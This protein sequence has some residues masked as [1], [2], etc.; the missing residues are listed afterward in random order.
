MSQKRG[1]SKPINKGQNINSSQWNRFRFS[2]FK[3]TMEHKDKIEPSL[4][5]ISS[6]KIDEP[7]EETQFSCLGRNTKVSKD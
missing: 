5:H 1:K 3:Q 6:I 7:T 4:G 2:S